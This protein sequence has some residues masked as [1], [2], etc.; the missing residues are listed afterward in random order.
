LKRV[1]ARRDEQ[2]AKPEAGNGPK[3]FSHD[4]FLTNEITLRKKIQS[5]S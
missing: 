2:P 3:D 1:R 5:R 4:D